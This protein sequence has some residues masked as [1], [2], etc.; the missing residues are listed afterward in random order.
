MNTQ[1]RRERIAELT[2]QLREK[3]LEVK[4]IFE[5]LDSLYE[6]QLEAA[7]AE[8]DNLRQRLEFSPDERRTREVQLCSALN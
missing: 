2:L 3:Q 5:E 8:N 1:E 7:Q 6:K 4:E